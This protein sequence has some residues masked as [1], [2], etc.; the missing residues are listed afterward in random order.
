MERLTARWARMPRWGH[1]LIFGNLCFF[2]AM[3]IAGISPLLGSYI[4]SEQLWLFIIL[5]ALL[6]PLSGSNALFNVVLYYGTWSLLG[7][8]CVHRFG[9]VKGMILAFGL[10]YGIGLAVTVYILTHISFTIF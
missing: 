8:L 6:W 1:G 5:L 2:A 3:A 10:I 4:G 9:E 7:A